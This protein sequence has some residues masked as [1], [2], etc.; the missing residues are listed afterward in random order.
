MTFL[1]IWGKRNAIPCTE[2]MHLE[3]LLSSPCLFLPPYP[4]SFYCLQ[5]CLSEA[6]S[7]AAEAASRSSTPPP[8]YTPPPP[9][10]AGAPSEGEE[11]EETS[12]AAAAGV[13]AAAAAGVS[14]A[15][16]AAAEEQSPSRSPLSI[17][18]LT[19]TKAKKN[20]QHLPPEDLPVL[21]LSLYPFSFFLALF[22]FV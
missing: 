2:I 17:T 10:V 3:F 4:P 8:S 16:A 18:G 1:C 19:G 22:R 14:A 21:L 9:P 12:A 5:N 7:A 11:E 6:K 13:S 20:P 15:A